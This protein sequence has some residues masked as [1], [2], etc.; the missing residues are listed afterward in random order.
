[1]SQVRDAVEGSGTVAEVRCI[2]IHSKGIEQT[3]GSGQTESDW[4]TQ[5]NE[6]TQG[7]SAT[8]QAASGHEAAIWCPSRGCSNHAYC[9]PAGRA[10]TG[11]FDLGSLDL[12]DFASPTAG[13][14]PAPSFRDPLATPAASGPPA[15]GR[16]KPASAKPTAAKSGGSGN[17]TLLWVGLAIAG[18]FVLLTIGGLA[19]YLMG[20]SESATAQ[21][22][23][24][25][26][27]EESAPLAGGETSAAGG[28]FPGGGDDTSS[29]AARDVAELAVP[30]SNNLSEFAD[31]AVSDPASSV[32]DASQN[33]A[34]VG[35]SAAAA[36]A[37]AASGDF[38]SYSCG[39]ASASFPP[40]KVLE[41]LP[42][43]IKGQAIRSEATKAMLY[44]A[45]GKIDAQIADKDKICREVQRLV[46]ADVYPGESCQ[47][48]NRVG[49]Q[50]RLSSGL[51]FPSMELELYIS[52]GEV[53]IIG[54][55][56]PQYEVDLFTPLIVQ[57]KKPPVEIDPIAVEAEKTVFLDSVQ[58]K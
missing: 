28:D 6:S 21:Q 46:M 45:V 53:I 52:D 20:S 5:G 15:L 43:G 26:T 54:W 19:I 9:R 27:T 2:L 58:F 44:L 47:R 39:S 22:S 36:A 37:L 30:D 1:M 8:S 42:T 11:G 29:I 31:P 4:S 48:S 18:L 49:I 14:F 55:G 32:A 24:S 57:D 17:K 56:R 16:P 7:R 23:D 10:G 13:G 34:S 50:A 33:P 35:D 38:K 12:P 25:P 40:G 3:K 51:V 41:E